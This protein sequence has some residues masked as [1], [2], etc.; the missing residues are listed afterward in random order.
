LRRLDTE[1]G[2]DVGRIIV[3]DAF[4]DVSALDL[5]TDER[6]VAVVGPDNAVNVFDTSTGR[7][8]GG[9]LNQPQ[10]SVNSVDF[11]QDGQTIVTA[12]DDKSVRLWD[13]RSGRQIGEPMIGHQNPVMSAAFSRDGSRLYSRSAESIWI[14]DTTT[15]RA[16]ATIGSPD[17]PYFVNAMAISPD[18]KRVAAGFT[19]IQQWD[20]DNGKAIGTTMTGHTESI[21]GLAYS[22]DGRYLVSAGMDK[23][24]RFWD[25]ASGRQI[26]DQLDT[27]KMGDTSELNFSEDGRRVFVA[28]SEVSLNNAP[29]YVGGGIFWLPAPSAWPDALCDKLTANPSQEQWK[30]W[31]SP[32]IPYSAPCRG[33]SS[34]P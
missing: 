12:G 7:P 13:W 11:S 22:P 18:G 19:G 10:D 29:P 17:K 3:S 23:T 15:R 20:A 26:G 27:T 16:I 14:W 28:A 34:P 33:K 8:F 6:W 21:T 25:T 4:Q 2:Q 31:I 9:P 32:D 30:A 5:S 24:L 1:G